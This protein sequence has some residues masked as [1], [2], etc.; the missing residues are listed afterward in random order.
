MGMSLTGAFNT[1]STLLVDLYPEQAAKATAANNFMRCLLGAGATAL[2]D[3]ML[4]AMGRGW[5]YTFIAF[6]MLGTSPL[7][8][9]VIRHGP[10]WR[11]ERRVKLEAR[12]GGS[13]TRVNNEPSEKR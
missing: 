3:P 10:R 2:I 12:N 9:F 13:N 4:N 1:V 8:L 7:L 6:V 5:C 11:E